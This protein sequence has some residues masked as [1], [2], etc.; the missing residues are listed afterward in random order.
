M[1]TEQYHRDGR[2]LWVELSA[3]LLKDDQGKV[4][5]ILGVSRDITERKQMD[6]ER[7]KL[8]GKNRHLQKSESLARMA[9]AIAHHFNN[10]LGVV[11]GSLELAMYDMPHDAATIN[12]LSTAMKASKMA[13]EMSRLMLTYSGK[14]P[15]N[16]SCLIFRKFACET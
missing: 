15:T 13:A 7:E 14:R 16:A 11:I 9:G 1:E 6:E 12:L 10:Q 8:E 2:T 5:G 4:V 3:V